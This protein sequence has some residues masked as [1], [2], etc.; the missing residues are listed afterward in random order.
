MGRK[1]IQHYQTTNAKPPWGEIAPHGTRIIHRAT[2]VVKHPSSIR[3]Q[4]YMN[5]SSSMRQRHISLFPQAIRNASSCRHKAFFIRFFNLSF[6]ISGQIIIWLHRSHPGVC[7]LNSSVGLG[8]P[9]GPLPMPYSIMPTLPH[10]CCA[11]Y[12]LFMP[13]ICDPDYASLLMCSI[14]LHVIDQ[15]FYYSRIIGLVHSADY[16]PRHPTLIAGTLSY[17]GE[18]HQL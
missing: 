4:C 1:P 18:T 15:M 10:H 8:P 12:P 16:Y 9:A 11:S 3:S 5:T 13:L 6:I 17:G 2:M 7:C 14:S